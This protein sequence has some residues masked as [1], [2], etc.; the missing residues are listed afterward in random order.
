MSCRNTE[1][2]IRVNG[3]RSTKIWGNFQGRS[4]NLM[5]PEGLR[6]HVFKC[7]IQLWE[8]IHKPAIQFQATAFLWGKNHHVCQAIGST[9][10]KNLIYHCNIWTD[11]L[12]HCFWRTL[13]RCFTCCRHVLAFHL[14]ISW[15]ISSGLLRGTDQQIGRGAAAGDSPKPWWQWLGGSEREAFFSLDP[16]S[17]WYFFCLVNQKRWV[18]YLCNTCELT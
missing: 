7:F 18:C 5:D 14:P 15:S 17:S 6:V 2:W 8:M 16:W 3:N 1:P 11:G 13:N 10:P 9:I 4:L 12:W